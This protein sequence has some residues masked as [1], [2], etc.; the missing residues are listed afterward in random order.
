MRRSPLVRCLDLGDET[1]LG[2]HVA[3]DEMPLQQEGDVVGTGFSDRGLRLA[4]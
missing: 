4:Y 1:G 3:A 2:D